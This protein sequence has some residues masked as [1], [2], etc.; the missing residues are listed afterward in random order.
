MASDAGILTV[1]LEATE[2]DPQVAGPGAR[3]SYGLAS[4][5][6]SASRA[7]RTHHAPENTGPAAQSRRPA[8]TRQQTPAPHSPYPQN[9]RRGDHPQGVKRLSLRRPASI[10][11][12][13]YAIVIVFG[14]TYGIV[15]A[16]SGRA[17]GGTAVVWGICVAGPLAL[18]FVWERLTGLK[19]FGVEVTLDQAIVRVDSSL[20]IA[21]S[22]QQYFSDSPAIFRL[23]D[24]VIGNRNIELLEVNLR[25]TGYW[26]ST[27]LYLQ[28]G[29]R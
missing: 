1:V 6:D 12:V 2:S 15:R 14:V 29:A 27:R 7:A 8:T 25:T 26:W 3:L 28:E 5:R 9:S 18:A 17:S 16:V 13:C 24:K 20:D 11:L 22:E 23:I 10:A 4:Q 21:L 19:V